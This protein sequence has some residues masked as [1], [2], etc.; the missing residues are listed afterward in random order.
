MVVILFTLLSV[1]WSKRDKYGWR[2]LF[3]EPP[4]GEESEQKGQQWYL[5]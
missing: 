4:S 2:N 1:P 5:R 3:A